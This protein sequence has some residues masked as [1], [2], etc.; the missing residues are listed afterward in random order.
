M[1]LQGMVPVPADDTIPVQIT[2]TVTAA[3]CNRP[4]R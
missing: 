3:R 4:I 1:T 2:D